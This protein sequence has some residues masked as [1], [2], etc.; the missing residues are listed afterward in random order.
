MSL[1]ISG[2]NVHGHSHGVLMTIYTPG[3]MPKA[4]VVMMPAAAAAAVSWSEP[5]TMGIM[6]AVGSSAAVSASGGGGASDVAAPATACEAVAPADAASCEGGAAASAAPA[7][8]EVLLAHGQ[9][10][11]SWEC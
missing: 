4:K 8:R 7:G 5:R 3:L 10:R 1:L 11:G 6:G 9:S 2:P